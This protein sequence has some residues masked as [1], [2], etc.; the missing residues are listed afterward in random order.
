MN[1]VPRRKPWVPPG[2]IRKN[3]LRVRLKLALYQAHCP[4]LG[5]VLCN[6]GVSENLLQ[7][8]R[9]EA[10]ISALQTIFPRRRNPNVDSPG[11]C[12]I[13]RSS[14]G[15]NFLCYLLSHPYCEPFILMLSRYLLP[16]LLSIYPRERKICPHKNL[17][18]YIHRN[19]IYNRQKN[20]NNPKFH[21]LLNG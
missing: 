8:H 20:E 13:P 7:Q 21:K 2:R 18:T 14:I 6:L 3:F 15:P 5:N 11:S 10:F 17:Y 9:T 16:L 12:T 1:E 19:I 4:V